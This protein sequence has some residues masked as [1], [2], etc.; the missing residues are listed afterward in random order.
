MRFICD[1][2]RLAQYPAA[3]NRKPAHVYQRIIAVSLILYLPEIQLSGS[4]QIMGH[5]KT[6]PRSRL[7]AG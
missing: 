4:K 7:D 2:R 1:F 3:A 6:A 5:T